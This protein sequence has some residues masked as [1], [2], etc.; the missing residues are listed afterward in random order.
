MSPLLSLLYLSS[1]CPLILSL[2]SLD[3][4]RVRSG[5]AEAL[6]GVL[7]CNKA[8]RRLSLDRNRLGAAGLQHLAEA[9]ALNNSLT[10]LR[11][12]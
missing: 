2:S 4:N 5:G 9:L 12:V 7:G 3:N 11:W 1:A 8:L 10:A 6:A